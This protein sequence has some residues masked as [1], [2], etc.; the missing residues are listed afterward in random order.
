MLVDVLLDKQLP[1]CGTYC[2]HNSCWMLINFHQVCRDSGLHP[3]EEGARLLQGQE[4]QH[5]RGGEGVRVIQVNVESL[6]TQ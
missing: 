4:G 6:G 2:S 1:T 3:A 5:D